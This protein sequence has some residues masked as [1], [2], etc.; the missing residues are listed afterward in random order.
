MVETFA[1]RQ[2]ARTLVAPAEKLIMAGTRPADIS[3]KVATAA[4]L[5]GLTST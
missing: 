5:A 2:A 4:P 3:P 1:A